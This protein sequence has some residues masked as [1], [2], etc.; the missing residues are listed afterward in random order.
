MVPT[1]TTYVSPDL[2]NQDLTFRSD[3]RIPLAFMYLER[4]NEVN[5]K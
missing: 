2:G 3:E 4:K 1:S 5:K